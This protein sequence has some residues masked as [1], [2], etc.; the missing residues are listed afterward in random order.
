MHK[1]LLSVIVLLTFRSIA[2]QEPASTWFDSPALTPYVHYAIQSGRMQLPFVLTQ[3]YYT[4][5]IRQAV[6]TS[7]K[8]GLPAW[9]QHWLRLLIQEIS[10]YH[11]TGKNEN[12]G[13]GYLGT[14]GVIR[15]YSD[16]DDQWTEA[17]GELEGKFTTP[18]FVLAQ[19]TVLDQHFKYDPA[20]S[21]DTG[22][23][24]YGRVETGYLLA[25]YKG[26]ALFL[27]RLGRNWGAPGERSLI[28][29]DNPYSFDV[30]GMQLGSRRFRFT[31]YTSRLNDMYGIDTQAANSTWK[32]YTR[33][34][35]V[36]RFD[37]ALGPNLQFGLSEAA[38]YGSVNGTW[39]MIYLNPL[40]LY[41]VEQRNNRVQMNGLWCG[42]LFWKPSPRLTFYLQ[43]LIDDIIVNNEPGQNDRARHPDRMGLTAKVVLADLPAP[44]TE[45]GLT[46]TRI[47][48]WTYMSYRNYENYI[49]NGIGMGYPANSIEQIGADFS[50]LGWKA[51]VVQMRA[52]YA[53]QGSQDMTAPFGDS[54][55]SFPYGTVSYWTRGEAS[56]AW[57]PSIFMDTSFFVALTHLDSPVVR[58]DIRLGVA[59]H[60]KYGWL[61]VF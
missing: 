53:R 1:H 16:R 25:R 38:V 32:D 11:R 22:E 10:S 40:N 47:G 18:W 8:R 37:V 41:Y 15:G 30:A 52:T 14:Q 42:D 17:R 28:L 34:W 55:D 21:G 9:Q 31:F 29:S 2:A 57:V 19:K 56:L 3:P 59:L 45:I 51:W 12:T 27:G 61:G 20:F 7:A 46:Y 5:E 39:Q 35:S 54:R 60:I 44:G 50:W 43:Y 4:L 48:N 13:F 23:W 24:I 49:S 6:L 36:K 58:D 26:A 33:F